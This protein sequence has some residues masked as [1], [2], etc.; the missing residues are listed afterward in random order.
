MYK[1]WQVPIFNPSLNIPRV[2]PK[3]KFLQHME[4]YLFTREVHITRTT[5]LLE[6]QTFIREDKLSASRNIRE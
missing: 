3:N 2:F 6:S 1:F 4:M 5:R